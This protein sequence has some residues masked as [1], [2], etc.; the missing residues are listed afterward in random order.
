MGLYETLPYDVVETFGP[1]ELRHYPK[2]MLASTKTKANKYNDS[3]FNNVFQYISGANEA[4][5]KISMT[6]PVISYE[7]EADTLVT[8]F[9]VPSKYDEHSVPRPATSSVFIDANEEGLFAVIRFRGS[10]S[11][12]NYD[13]QDEQLKSFLEEHHYKLLSPRL[14]FRYQ[15]PFVPGVFRRNEIAYRVSKET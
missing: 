11:E 7:D 12:S 14:V 1:I 15:P 4:K 2:F 8:G 6:T 10:W 13:K 5:E 9:Y 3:G